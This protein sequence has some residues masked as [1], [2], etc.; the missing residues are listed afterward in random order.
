MD[1]PAQQV[2]VALVSFLLSS[3]LSEAAGEEGEKHVT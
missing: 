2:F 1:Q 3:I